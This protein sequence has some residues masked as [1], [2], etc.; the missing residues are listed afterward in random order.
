EGIGEDFWP[1]TF[2]PSVVDRYVRV[3]DRESFR[4]ARAITRQEG[5]LVGGSSGTALAA[6]LEVAGNLDADA[7]VVVIFPDT[8]RNYLSKLYSDAWL[9]QYGL[10]DRPQLVRVEAVL[11]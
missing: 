10:L 7:T 2:D 9:L 11:P 5:I 3:S 8:G 1:E 4:L 6:A